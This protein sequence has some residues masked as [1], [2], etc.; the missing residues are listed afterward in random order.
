MFE[1]VL[2]IALASIISATITTLYLNHRVEN[3][4]N[5]LKIENRIL[6]TMIGTLEVDLRSLESRIEYLEASTTRLSSEEG[7][8][9]LGINRGYVR[10]ESI[11]A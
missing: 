6:R 2:E 8:L 9:G 1:I 11:V 5:K 4:I 3:K 7:I 10:E